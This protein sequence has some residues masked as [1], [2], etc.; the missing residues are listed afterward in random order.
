MYGPISPTYKDSIS[1]LKHAK[2]LSISSKEWKPWNKSTN[3]EHF[4]KQSN[5]HMPTVMVTVGIK[6]QDKPPHH[7][8]SIRDEIASSRK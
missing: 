2:R 8:T 1:K 7:P 3:E 5:G 4:L 6:N